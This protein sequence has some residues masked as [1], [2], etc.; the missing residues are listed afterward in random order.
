MRGSTDRLRVLVIALSART[1]GGASHLVNQVSALSSI[2]GTDITVHARSALAERLRR[3]APRAR[4]IGHETRPLA[5]RVIFE[6]LI[7]P[8]RER[9]HDVIYIPGNLGLIMS[10]RPQVVCQQ[11]AWYFT[12]AIREFRRTRCS[13]LMRV[14]LAVE[15]AAARWSVRHATAVVTVSETM[16]Q[17]I[18]SDLGRLECLRVIASAPPNL[19]SEAGSSHQP[20]GYALAVAHDDP[21]KDHD[22]LV[23]AFGRHRDLPPLVIA[24]RCRDARR[25]LLEQRG[26]GRVQLLGQIGDSSRLAQL[27]RG[28]SCVVAHSRFESFGLT[29]A[30]ALSFQ[31]AI[32]ASDIPAHREVCGPVAHYYPPGDLDALAAAVRSACAHRA[33]PSAEAPAATRTWLQ[34]AAELADVLGA[35]ARGS[36]SLKSRHRHRGLRRARTGRP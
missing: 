4:I 20:A 16:R 1:G 34:N 11:N 26:N 6:Q 17:M 8:W 9:D 35:A 28:A 36:S 22:G 7:V 15:S 25:Q 21:H 19:G 10:P 29:P 14:R 30:E 23:E 2:D 24:G 3:A 33:P 31:K 27:Y 5:L 18:E 12:D 32:V 13:R